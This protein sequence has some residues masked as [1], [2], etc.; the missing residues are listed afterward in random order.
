[1]PLTFRSLLT[2]TLT[3][4]TGCTSSRPQE[5]FSRVTT[6]AP[7]ASV[8]ANSS[9]SEAQSA[10]AGEII[11]VSAQ[12]VQALPPE[13]SPSASAS[14]ALPESQVIPSGDAETQSANPET[15]ASE[16]ANPYA[17]I[18][19]ADH[20]TGSGKLISLDDVI[21]SVY[22]SYPDLAAAEQERNVAFGNQ[23][24][25]SGEFDTK[26]YADSNNQPVGFYRTFRQTVG[27]YLPM[28]N[29]GQV[30]TQYR[31]GRGEFEPWYEER[32]TNEGGEFKLGVEKPLLRNLEIDP[33]RAQLW[34][35]G[36]QR[37]AVEPDIQAQ[38]IQFVLESSYAYW[39]WVAAGHNYQVKRVLLKLAEDRN[40]QIRLEVERGKK[41]RPVLQDNLRVIAS[42]Q[43][44]LIEAELKVQQSAI[45]LSQYYRDVNG[46]PV[47]PTLEQLPDFPEIEKLP[48][49]QLPLDLQLANSRRPELT[50][51]D[52]IKKE[53]DIEYALASN[54]LQP[55][56]NAYAVGSQDVGFPTSSSKDKSRFEYETGLAFEVPLQ[57][58]KAKGKLTATQAKMTQVA[59]KRQLTSDKISIDVQRAVAAINA[60]YQVIEQ[61]VRNVELA[62]YMAQVERRVFEVGRTDL[63]LL[64]S[65]EEIAVNA[66]T[67][68]IE[69]KLK[70]FLSRADYRAALALD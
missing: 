21:G 61:E 22:Y 6:A 53:L 3:V 59:Y 8:A 34:I 12:E 36:V 4:V 45:K 20:L 38:R 44:A 58:R 63:F 5:T 54:D 43:A 32:E 30:F 1:M 9:T 23:L 69:A 28:Y 7:S 50:V 13:P 46:R 27:A 19:A 64:N 35:S 25:A 52:F 65:R 68:L 10:G 29:G 15:L 16:A 26:L 55:D 41:D 62:T 60:N 42:R 57:R 18:I 48:A 33:R 56:L 37:Q 47:V 51:L 49:D 70:Y 31:V 66:A 17:E 40:D 24:L 11:P 39:M 67:T 14:P 2:I